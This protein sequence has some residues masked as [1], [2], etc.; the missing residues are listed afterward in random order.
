[1]RPPTRTPRGPSRRARDR[2]GRPAMT[3][4]ELPGSSTGSSADPSTPDSSTPDT[5]A[6]S[7]ATS[8]TQPVAEEAQPVPARADGLELLGEIPG[9]GY[10]QTPSLVRRRDG[11][12]LQ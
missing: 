8:V 7:T 9:S 10:R 5:A 4:T 3:T 6:A 1:M 11:Q 2:S 12:T